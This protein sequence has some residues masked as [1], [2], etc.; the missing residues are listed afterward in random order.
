MFLISCSTEPI[1][2]Y[3][4]KD[5]E[6]QPQMLDRAI[7]IGIQTVVRQTR[8]L[9]RPLTI[10][11]LEPSLLTENEKISKDLLVYIQE[12]ATTKIALQ[13]NFKI[14]ERT[15][16]NQVLS[17][18]KLNQT[19]LFINSL[20]RKEFGKLIGADAILT[21]SIQ[22]LPYDLKMNLRLVETETGVGIAAGSVRIQKDELALKLMGKKLPGTLSIISN[23]IS[24]LYIDN[25]YYSVISEKIE[26]TLPPSS[27]SIRIEKNGFS[28][29]RGIIQIGEKEYKKLEV[30]F[31]RPYI[32]PVKSLIAGA[33]IPGL[34]LSWY[35]RGSNDNSVWIDRLCVFGFYISG[36][37]AAY[38]IYKRPNNFLT[39]ADE[40]SYNEI[41][42]TEMITATGFYVA[43]L[44]ASVFVGYDFMERNSFGRE[45]N[46]SGSTIKTRYTYIPPSELRKNHE[47]GIQF[48]F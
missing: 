4:P 1:I 46:Q 29:Y 39:K 21:I 44:V 35:G 13:P 45:I 16:L 23:G 43:H 25:E 20:A 27:Y 24:T 10:A 12:D 15:Q 2:Q 31:S 22:N 11:I 6:D 42:K 40:D 30:E 37:M 8:E 18:L 14:V 34:E 17:E 5:I 36:S 32:A 48:N 26:L 7:D 38:D 47:F 28:P 33:V 41:V 9:N 19:D 3:V